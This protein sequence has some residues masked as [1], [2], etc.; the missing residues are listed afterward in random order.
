MCSRVVARLPQRLNQRF[1][2]K[3]LHS[4]GPLWLGTAMYDLKKCLI[5]EAN[6]AELDFFRILEHSMSSVSQWS[7]YLIHSIFL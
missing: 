1:L 5:L 4:A 7:F 6:K 2:K 3:N